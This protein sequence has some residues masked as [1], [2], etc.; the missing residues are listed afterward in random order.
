MK[1]VIQWWNYRET[2]LPVKIPSK[3]RR[4]QTSKACSEQIG[5]SFYYFSLGGERVS[6]EW[7]MLQAPP[8][9]VGV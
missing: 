4:R 6:G 2:S 5:G 3:A 9:G 7:V 8:I 1:K